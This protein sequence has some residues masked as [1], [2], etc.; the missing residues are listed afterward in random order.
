M[1]K[2]HKKRTAD[3]ISPMHSKN[4]GDN[5][6]QSKMAT[7]KDKTP[8]QGM[9]SSQQTCLL[10]GHTVNH[11]NQSYT[12]PPVY[13]YLETFIGMNPISPG[14]SQSSPHFSLTTQMNS[15]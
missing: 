7:A 3:E 6:R 5:K 4:K 11:A 13:H 2:S 1:G 8:P 10:T 9:N 15:D 14:Y 12:L